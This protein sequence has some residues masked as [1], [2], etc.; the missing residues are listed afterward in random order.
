MN[1]TLL[2]GKKIAAGV[3]AQVKADCLSFVQ[4]YKRPPGLAVIM[5]GDDPASTIYVRN[6][7]KACN[8]TGIAYFEEHLP[9]TAKSEDILELIR[10]FNCEE[11]CD[12]LLVQLPL[13][14]GIDSD[15]LL[16]QIDYR[17]DVDGFHPVNTGKL[18]MD[19]STISPCT[20]GGI[21]KMLDAYDIPIEGRRAVIIGRSSIV[22]KPM[23]ALLLSRHATV[24]I[25][26][27]RTDNLQVLCRE[28]DILV[29]AIGKPGF[30]DRD[31]IKPGA[32][33]IDVG[34]NRIE[35]SSADPKWLSPDSP[36]RDKLHEKGFALIG[37]VHPGA[38]REISAYYTPVPGGVGRMTVAMLMHNT[39][40]QAFARQNHKQ[41]SL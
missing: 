31:F 38:A 25:A 8:R 4:S 20:P 23:A 37:D 17:K 11:F 40:T 12:G 33:I 13:P 3:L 30:V 18:W 21:M 1:T 32:V 19:R 9:G 35:K 24:T 6:K 41:G 10:H 34:I 39:I 28:A 5:A 7:Q 15:S 22:G 29:A 16:E 27:S 26:H 2:D 14:D 36:I